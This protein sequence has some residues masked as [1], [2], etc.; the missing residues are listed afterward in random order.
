MKKPQEIRNE[1]LS[2]FMHLDEH[3]RSSPA[4]H[5]DGEL[6]SHLD[7]ELSEKLM[8]TIALMMEHYKK[9]IPE[10]KVKRKWGEEMN[11]ADKLLKKYADFSGKE[12]TLKR[13]FDSSGFLEA[14]DFY[15]FDF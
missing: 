2:A 13:E 6:V 4:N 3:Y 15:K 12:I 10:M 9:R 5:D 7:I 8:Q 11:R 14:R 1:L